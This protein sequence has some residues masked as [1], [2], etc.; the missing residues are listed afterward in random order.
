MALRSPGALGFGGPRRLAMPPLRHHTRTQRERLL[1]ISGQSRATI[2]GQSGVGVAPE[3]EQMGW[4][5]HTSCAH[6]TGIAPSCFICEK[7]STTPQVSAI[8]PLTNRKIMIS[9]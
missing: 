6:P 5:H 1:P 2:F 4:E 8:R 3:R 7:T 9:L